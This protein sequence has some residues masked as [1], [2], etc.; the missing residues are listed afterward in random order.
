MLTDNVGPKECSFFGVVVCRCANYVL[1]AFAGVVY[2]GGLNGA[3]V[4]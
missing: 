1:N 2:V 3:V 4:I